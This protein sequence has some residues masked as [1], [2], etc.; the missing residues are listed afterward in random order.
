MGDW[1][2]KRNDVVGAAMWNWEPEERA[3]HVL[4]VY[5]LGFLHTR[6]AVSFKCTCVFTFLFLEVATSTYF[7][8]TSR[9][10]WQKAGYD[11]S[12]TKVSVTLLSQVMAR[13]WIFNRLIWHGDNLNRQKYLTSCTV[14]ILIT[15][16]F[17]TKQQV[18][19]SRPSAS[20]SK[21]HRHRWSDFDQISQNNWSYCPI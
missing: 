3:L 19:G 5:F 13:I 1:S 17:F 15:S 14:L 9:K 7:P 2:T 11:W 10:S 20:C 4:F 8:M 18:I 16:L 6:Q 21:C 12:G